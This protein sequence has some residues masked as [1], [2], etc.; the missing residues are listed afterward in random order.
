M[1]SPDVTELLAGSRAGDTEATARLMAAVYDELHRIALAQRPHPDAT[2]TATSLVHEAYVKMVDGE[3]LP[4]DDRAHFFASAARAM[5]QVVVDDARA[6]GRAKRGG[7]ERPLRLDDGL[8]A[9]APAAP[10]RVVALDEAL[11][12]FEALDARAAQ[13]V[14]CRYFA[15]LT[16]E[17]TADALGLSPTTVKRD[18][19]TAR[20]WL[21]RALSDEPA[22]NGPGAAETS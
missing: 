11:R 14:E 1:A 2:L 5:R 16:V 7:G 17:E 4:F 13:V 12:R 19:Q 15:G 3:R 6:K 10:E 9:P 8:D 22:S 18:W 20:A 21:H